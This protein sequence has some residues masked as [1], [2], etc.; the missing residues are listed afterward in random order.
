MTK[1]NVLN[2]EGR[3]VVLQ[4]TLAPIVTEALGVIVKNDDDMLRAT[5]YLSR[6]NKINDQITEEKERV[7]KPLNEALRVERGRWKP[8]EDMYKKG[9]EWLRLQT[10]KYQ[11]EKIK[12]QREEEA[13]VAQRLA[14]GKI[15]VEKAGK[16]LE[17]LEVVDKVEGTEGKLT[18]RETQVL[19]IVDAKQIP[20]EYLVAD[21]EKILEA[22]KA[23]EKVD[24][25]KLDIEMVPVNRR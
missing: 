15:S 18:F 1:K 5:D 6:L 20:R 16:Q 12:K 17:K 8:A 3:E 4:T 23:G 14:E 9:I 21:E 10:S 11:T 25:C 2:S 13:K 19:V 7:T 24:G 22:L